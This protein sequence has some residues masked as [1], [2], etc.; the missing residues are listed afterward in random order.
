MAT[1]DITTAGPH[2]VRES[3]ERGREELK[4]L[5][6]KVGLPVVDVF[7]VGHCGAAVQFP[8]FNYAGCVSDFW[9]EA[10]KLVEEGLVRT[11]GVNNMS[12]HQVK[13]VCEFAKI[14]PSVMTAEAS[15]GERGGPKGGVL[16]HDPV[17]RARAQ[18]SPHRS[19]STS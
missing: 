18:P 17:H 5:E 3:F 6:E 4:R 14:M 7:F 11:L 2:M 15:D 8:D 12:I 1:M 9:R 13:S 16:A 10:E 19:S